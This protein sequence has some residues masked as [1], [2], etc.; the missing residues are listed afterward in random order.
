MISDDTA[1]ESENTEI[2]G[3]IGGA[4]AVPDWRQV[5]VSYLNLMALVVPLLMKRGSRGSPRSAR[6]SSQ[7]CQY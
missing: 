6:D 2:S 1:D 3:E 5:L 4:T 7:R